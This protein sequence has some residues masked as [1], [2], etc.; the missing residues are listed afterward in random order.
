MRAPEFQCIKSRADFWRLAPAVILLLAL[1]RLLTQVIGP[2][3]QYIACLLAVVPWLM[4]CTQHLRDAVLRPWW[5]LISQVP[6]ACILALPGKAEAL[7]QAT[8]G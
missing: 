8:A 5:Q 7:E 3:L 2:L 4:A 6:V 1:A